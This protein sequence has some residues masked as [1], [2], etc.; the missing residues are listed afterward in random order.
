MG[1]PKLALAFGSSTL[2]G[3]VVDAAKTAELSPIVVVTGFHEHEVSGAV[4]SAARVVRNSDPGAGNVS[5]LLVG[6]DA[7]G[8][9]DG[10][11]LLLGDMPSVNWEL[12]RQLADGMTESGSG[13]GW[14][15]YSN[16]RGHPVA[17]ARSVFGDVRLLSG[18]KALWPFLSSMDQEETCVVRSDAP[19]PLDV[20]TPEDYARLTVQQKSR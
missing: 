10:L 14:V 20:N 8:D 6:M 18:S 17:L 5:S 19:R 15:E 9:V 3:A 2:V 12:I 4:G 1:R 13:A 7:C 16:G 11:V